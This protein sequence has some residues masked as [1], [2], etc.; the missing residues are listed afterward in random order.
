MF[1]VFL[2]WATAHGQ[3]GQN[4]ECP[5]GWKYHLLP[6]GDTY[7]ANNIK[8][9]YPNQQNLFDPDGAR[10]V[11]D[12]K[13][14]PKGK[15]ATSSNGKDLNSK[16]G[17]AYKGHYCYKYYGVK[18][19]Y[20]HAQKT[21]RES[22]AN[23]MSIHHEDE[24]NIL[25]GVCKVTGV[26]EECWVGFIDCYKWNYKNHNACGEKKKWGSWKDTGNGPWFGSD[27]SVTGN[28]ERFTAWKKNEPS[29]EGG[30]G[31]SCVACSND[32]S[33]WEDVSCD[34][35]ENYYACKRPA[36]IPKGA[37][38]LINPVTGICTERWGP[39]QKAYEGR[40]FDKEYCPKG[41]YNDRFI[42]PLHKA[43][44]GVCGPGAT[45]TD[46][47]GGTDIWCKNCPSGRYGDKEGLES[48]DCTA[49]CVG[50][51]AGSSGLEQSQI[52]EAGKYMHQT[53]SICL[54][55][56][57]G[58]YC[59]EGST[60]HCP[61]TCPAGRY[62]QKGGG[63]KDEGCLSLCAEGFFC[64]HYSVAQTLGEDC[65]T[66]A[67]LKKVNYQDVIVC[68][69]NYGYYQA[70]KVLECG[71]VGKYCPAGAVAPIYVSPGYQGVPRNSKRATKQ[72]ICTVGHYCPGG[73]IEPYNSPGT[74]SS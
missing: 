41:T 57:E 18:L 19:K 20:L 1:V 71:H 12:V 43:N 26:S 32:C 10:Y 33:V 62:G 38:R 15:P 37:Y 44:I 16:T 61:A 45:V 66:G 46:K 40:F 39:E 58:C 25:Q 60:R 2:S 70:D 67:Y 63:D 28:N 65:A 56:S 13:N 34:L 53:K 64:P 35:K 74:V 50:C 23:I 3:S 72:S 27:G 30:Y 55:C 24:F 14:I 21:C 52:C 59:K 29:N 31:R 8:V 42:D 6:Y 11:G 73:Q 68:K 48:S 9:S 17:G 22:H 4:P 51:E 49:A 54:T 5:D 36:K 7:E 69:I 47:N